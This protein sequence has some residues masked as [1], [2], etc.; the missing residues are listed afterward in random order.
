MSDAAVCLSCGWPLPTLGA[1]PTLA[2]LIVAALREHPGEGLVVGRL[3]R[4]VHRRRVDV[5]AELARLAATGTVSR[6]EPRG[7]GKG[8]RGRA[9]TLEG[10]GTHLG[11]PMEPPRAGSGASGSS[12]ADSPPA[13]ASADGALLGLLLAAVYGES[14]AER[15]TAVALLALLVA[16]VL[17]VGRPAAAMK[18][19]PGA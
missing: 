14:R 16:A 5:E 7:V 17:A 1:P 8:S 19:V 4:T 12:P 9:W 15:L 10:A 11:R 6:S 2:E 3:A 18:G 13:G